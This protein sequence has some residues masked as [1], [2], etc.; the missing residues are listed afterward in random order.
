M[1]ANDRTRS[2]SEVEF[3]RELHDPCVTGSID[4][5]KCVGVEVRGRIPSD[6]TVQH[7]KCF[8][9]KLQS[10]SFPELEGSRQGHIQLP[11][12]GTFDIVG[13][14][15]SQC[16][17]CRLLKRSGIEEMG[18]GVAAAVNVWEYLVRPLWI[19]ISIQGAI[20]TTQDSQPLAR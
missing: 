6:E 5:A 15:I 11:G 1:S 20:Q 10:L 13:F 17:Q 18:V 9:S 4:L 19:S 8:G 3:Q 14:H 7:I 2:V 16:A 12:S